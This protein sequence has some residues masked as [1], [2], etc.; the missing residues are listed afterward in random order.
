MKKTTTARKPVGGKKR[1]IMKVSKNPVRPT[2]YE[3][4]FDV[5]NKLDG[6]F[7]FT[8]DQKGKAHGNMDIRRDSYPENRDEVYHSKYTLHDI[9]KW[10]QSGKKKPLDETH[11]Y[12]RHLLE[13]WGG[14]YEKT[15]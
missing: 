14:K 8:I 7:S 9:K 13:P 10:E 5:E 3:H 15:K 11:W 2:K 6:S 1:P 12:Y 4:Q